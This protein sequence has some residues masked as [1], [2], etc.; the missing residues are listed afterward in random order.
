MPILYLLIGVFA[1]HSNRDLPDLF[2]VGHANALLN[3]LS[4]VLSNSRAL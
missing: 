4:S 2:A 1:A 3:A